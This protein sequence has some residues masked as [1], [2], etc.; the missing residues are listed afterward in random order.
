M[1]FWALKNRLWEHQPDFLRKVQKILYF[2]LFSENNWSKLFLWTLKKFLRTPATFFHSKSEEIFKCKKFF[3]SSL[4]SFRCT[5]RNQFWDYHSF[6]PSKVELLLF[7]L[8]TYLFDMYL[9]SI[10]LEM[11]KLEEF[12]VFIAMNSAIQ[13]V[14]ETFSSSMINHCFIGESLIFNR[15]NIAPFSE[16]KLWKRGWNIG[17][18]SKCQKFFMMFD[19]E[20]M[21][22]SRM[23]LITTLVNH[24]CY[25]PVF[26]DRNKQ[27]ATTG[28]SQHWTKS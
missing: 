12:V 27:N 24:E 20:L 1:I 22:A 15:W 13:H 18:T 2:K 14:R 3:K 16:E 11:M 9:G 17:V 5:Y 23:L 4:K 10:W 25:Q 21:D 19:V 8:L 28:A 26:R 6:F 7:C